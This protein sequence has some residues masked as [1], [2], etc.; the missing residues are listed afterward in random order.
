MPYQFRDSINQK[1][2]MKDNS[3]VFK[4][5]IPLIMIIL[6]LSVQLPAQHSIRFQ[7]LSIEH[8]L[9]QSAVYCILQDRKGFMWFGTEAGLNK[10]DGYNFT[11]YKP[12]E[13]NPNSISN[14]FI[15]AILEDHLGVLWVGT[16]D[17]LNRFNQEK[18]QFIHYE[19]QPN[20]PH[21]LIS[22][23][24]F[25][26]FE[27]KSGTLWIGTDNGLNKFDRDKEQFT[28][29]QSNP[30]DPYSLSHNDIRRICEDRAGSLWVGTYG[31]GLDKLDR[32]R[33]RFI[34]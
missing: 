26:I 22:N 23:R 21:S 5:I 12:E 27:D 24:V 13:G 29:Y 6:N 32:A 30:N 28:R 10:Y 18:E 11:V 33:K 3:L 4:I 34:R 31:G 17:G 16:E 2:R 8:G 25:V 7:H 1:V 20:N 19:S 14:N 15:Y 9:S